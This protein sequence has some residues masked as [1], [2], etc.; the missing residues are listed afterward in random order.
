MVTLP[1]GERIGLCPTKAKPMLRATQYEFIIGEMRK[2][3]AE[4]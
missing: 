3:A 2:N 4:R 1:D